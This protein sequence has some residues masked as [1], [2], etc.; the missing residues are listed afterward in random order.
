MIFLDPF[1]S[2]YQE[3]AFYQVKDRQTL[4]FSATFTPDVQDL[5]AKIMKDDHAFV[6]NGKTIAAN[7]L[8]E[9]NFIEVSQISSISVLL[10]GYLTSG[11]FPL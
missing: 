7:P 11:Q 1:V 8:V 2:K 3:F 4:L 10:H 5:A 6:S 9:Q